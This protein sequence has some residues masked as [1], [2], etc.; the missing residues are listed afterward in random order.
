MD[1]EAAGVLVL[2]LGVALIGWRWGRTPGVAAAV[3]ALV[4]VGARDWL[5]DAYAPTL[6]YLVGAAGLTMVGLLAG[7]DGH[8]G[9]R[10]A[11]RH[12]IDSLTAREREVLDLVAAGKSNAEIA[13]NLFLSEH[14]VKTHVKH[15][16]AKLRVRNRT[17]AA[18]AL[19][20]AERF[21]P[22]SSQEFSSGAVRP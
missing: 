9:H 16:L 10:A 14:T 17:E 15:I 7:V 20:S 18:L 5:I 11:A 13:D 19:V 12:R 8:R 3:V 2:T 21:L 22:R 6:N 1:A 4:L